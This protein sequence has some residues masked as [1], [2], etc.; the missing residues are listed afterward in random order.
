MFQLHLAKADI[1]LLFYKL[2]FSN[3]SLIRLLH[4]VIVVEW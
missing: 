3:L 2:N 1:Y 4:R